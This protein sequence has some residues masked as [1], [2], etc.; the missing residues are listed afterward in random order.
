MPES[1]AITGAGQVFQTGTRSFKQPRSKL[2]KFEA[3][4]ASKKTRRRE[5]KKRKFGPDL[6]LSNPIPAL[7]FFSS[8]PSRHPLHDQY[9]ISF[10]ENLAALS[11][12]LKFSWTNGT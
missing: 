10:W 11:T 7:L 2:V 1:I 8:P 4:E 3:C 6:I 12:A 9:F 5:A